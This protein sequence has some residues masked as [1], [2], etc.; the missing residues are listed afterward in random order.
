MRPLGPFAASYANLAAARM[1][2]RRAFLPIAHL[3]AQ[4]LP[5]RRHTASI[6]GGIEYV[7]FSRV[8]RVVYVVL[9]ADVPRM[10]KVV[11]VVLAADVPRVLAV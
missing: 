10:L 6:L 7:S 2:P 5:R 3:V 11:Y 4:M 8:L 1:T 9:A